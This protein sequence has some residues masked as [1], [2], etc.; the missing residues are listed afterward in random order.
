M[1][2]TATTPPAPV[3]EPR[4]LGT[5]AAATAVTMWGLGNTLI[6]S[7]PMPGLAV[8]F[9]R[10]LFAVCLYVPIL[11]LRG[12]R[13]SA[14]SFRFGWRGG[15][16]FGVDIAAFFVAIHLTTVAN[17]TT[18]NALQPLVIMGFAA[19]MFGER[20][21]R[22]HVVCALV[23]TGGVAMVALGA[24]GNGT[25]DLAGD[26]MA[27]VALF[28]WAWYFIASKSARRNL[29]TFEYMTVMNMV[30]FAVVVPMALVGGDLFGGQGAPS[31]ERLLP[32]LF[33]V[34]IPGSGHIIMNWAHGHTT[35][36]IT[37]LATL[38]MPVLSTAS[39]AVFLD[40]PVA[41]VQAVGIA[42]VVVALAVVV[43]TD[44]RTARRG[45]GA[46]P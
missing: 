13:L 7:V 32:V 24:A 27:V 31:V 12:G 2:A 42:V 16:A 37:S 15:V 40:Q 39:A 43:M 18:I 14:R 28:A 23:A 11:Y 22:H 6:A 20:V 29:D 33:I 41:A 9:W 1:P 25:G 26:L 44:T 45:L 19:V 35:L 17:A 46:Q 3:A 36:V 30:A 38:M 10:L 21:G 8:A 34:L 5:L 4:P